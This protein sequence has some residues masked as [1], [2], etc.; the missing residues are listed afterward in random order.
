MFREFF[1]FELRFQLRQPLLWIAAALFGLMAFAASTS[2]AVQL[3]GAIGNI[4]RN[5]PIVIVQFM[6]I[7]TV[8][9]LLIV[10]AFLPGALLR[11]HELNTAELFFAKPM[12][13]GDYLAGRL[14]GGLTATLMIYV[15]IIL[16]MLLGTA[17][18]WLD[19]ARLGPVSLTPYLW[20]LVIMVIPNVLFTGAVLSLFAVLMRNLLGVYIGIAGFIVLW[21][22]ATTMTA[23]LDNQWLSALLDPFGLNAFGQETRY[24]SAAEQNSQLPALNHYLLANR[25]LWLGA[26]ALLAVLSYLLFKPMRAGTGRGWRK[27]I[28]ASEAAVTSKPNNYQPVTPSF[29]AATRWQQWLAQWRFD[30]VGVL[31]SVPFIVMLGFGLLNFIASV[32]LGGAMYGTAVY[33]VTYMVTDALAGS[34]NF[35]LILIVTF[36]AGELI[37]KERSAKIGD[38]T[39]ALPIPNWLPLTAKAMALI[40]VVFT[41]LASGIIAGVCYQLVKGYTNFEIGLYLSEMVLEALPFI[42]MGLLALALQIIFQNKFIG[43]LA[44]II[45]I[46]ARTALRSL[47]FEHQLYTFGL[48]TLLPYSDMNGY[49]HLLTGHLAFRGYWL[50]FSAML[51]VL[52]TAL[53]VRG[54]VPSFSVRLRDAGRKLRGPLGATFAV[55]M[56]AWLGL[57][58]WI[59]WNTNIVNPYVTADD[60]LDWQADYER[61]YGQYKDL[62]QPRITGIKVDLDMY[63]GERRAVARGHYELINRS[64]SAITD[65][66]V[67]LNNTDVQLQ[68]ISL[69]DSS[70]QHENKLFGYRIYR[71]PQPLQPGATMTLDFTVEYAKRGFATRDNDSY[72]VDNGS[73]I[74]NAELLPQFGYN[75]DLPITDRNERRKRDLPER[76]RMPKLEDEAARANTYITDDGDWISFETTVSTVPDQIA[77]SPG[78]LQKEWLE[79]GRRY[80]HYKMDVPMLPFFS[81]LSA[82]WEVKRDSWNGLPI[83]VY[84]DKK[85][86]YNVDRMIS[87]VKDSLD[88]FTSQFSPYQHKQVRILEFP[89]YASFAQSFA[90]TIPYS[91]SIGFIADL[92]EKE[93]IDYVYY[94]TAH[95]IAHQWWAHQVIGANVQG[96]TVLSESLSQ[97]SALMV[98]EKAYGRHQ[99]RQFL[100]NELDGYL[101]ARGG[102]LLEELPLY[103][104][105]NQ[106]YIHYEKGSLVFYRLR[107]EIGEEALNRALSKFLKDKGYQNAPFTTSA[108]LLD[109]IR[110]ETPVDRQQLVTDLFEKISFYDNRMKTATAKKRAD[111]KY[112]VTLEFSADKRYAD[113]VGTETEGQL[114]DWIEVGVFARKPGT[115]ERD[116]TV[117][118]LERRHITDKQHTLTVT[119]DAEPYEAG[120][121]PYNKLIDRVSNDN[122]KR[123]TIE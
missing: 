81:W 58:S 53:W 82:R 41:F 10:T 78:Y 65:V 68:S 114:D 15:V 119:V 50:L 74:N 19:P 93:D 21:S 7:F 12:R 3:G 62:P 90:N 6:S 40:S 49:G 24:W 11:D 29:S 8:L 2:D 28:L 51:L 97:Y 44:I 113:G 91:E 5:A 107:D 77:L 35:L 23:D 56:V 100:K 57:G 111:G 115:E 69:P 33:P 101:R 79:N 1:R 72:I 43:Y 63:P 45:V 67:A 95:E 48:A 84:Y 27:K 32:S 47:D 75:D 26:S 54:I 17:M 22:V 94:V 80:F 18:P 92:R 98:M 73:F 59:F 120:F 121:D 16:A 116:E 83:E 52:C 31:K 109:Y 87:S 108:E 14:L 118:H 104:V 42:L 64:D 36:Y 122:R 46:V 55:F 66:H 20:T 37:W 25:V 89:R 105:E 110:A 70:L 9:G 99:M 4:H 102:E 38:V 13:K 61:Q 85:H 39:D 30:T 60:A 123:V 88:Y 112:D 117:L 96:A 34:F 106:Q 71:L 103:R 76:Q 86:P